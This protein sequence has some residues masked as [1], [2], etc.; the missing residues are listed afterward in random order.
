MFVLALGQRP[1]G[2]SFFPCRPFQGY[3][4]EQAHLWEFAFT[5]APDRGV[6][7]LRYGH[8]LPYWVPYKHEAQRNALHSFVEGPKAPE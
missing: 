6:L 8:G 7:A 5:P 1:T 3:P 4:G 2:I